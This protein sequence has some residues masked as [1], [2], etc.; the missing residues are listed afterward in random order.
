MPR[1]SEEEKPS[2]SM[3]WG[4]CSRRPRLTSRLHMTPEETITATLETSYVPGAALRAF[5]M[6]RAKLSP[7][8]A[9]DWGL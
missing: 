2:L 4:M 8:M 7:T 5:R 6:G 1:A 9:R 3:A